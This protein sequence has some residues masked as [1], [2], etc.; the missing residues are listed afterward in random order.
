[1]KGIDKCM[2]KLLEIY[3]KIVTDKSM[4][5]IDKCKKKLLDIY[6]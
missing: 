2:K 6:I 1:M 3:I 5:D 4:K